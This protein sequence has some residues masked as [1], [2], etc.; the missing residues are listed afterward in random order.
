MDI[1]KTDLIKIIREELARARP[2]IENEAASSPHAGRSHE[3][4]ANWY[5]GKWDK[6]RE[7]M[8]QAMSRPSAD[9]WVNQIA[10]DAIDQ[11]KHEPEIAEEYYPHLSEVELNKLIR[12]LEE[13][14][15]LNTP[16]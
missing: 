7:Q 2:L 3:Q 15:R 16:R 10:Q 12:I 6:M 14:V 11:I 8:T 1:S 13:D 4:I 5:I 9:H